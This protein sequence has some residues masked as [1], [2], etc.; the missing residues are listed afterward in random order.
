MFS[1]SPRVKAQ[2]LPRL[3]SRW[4][5]LRAVILKECSREALEGP[6]ESLKS[7]VRNTNALMMSVL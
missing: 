3:Q 6:L 2:A 7:N 5:K 1:F 4:I